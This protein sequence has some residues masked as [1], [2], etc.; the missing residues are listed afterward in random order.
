ML[1]VIKKMLIQL[2]STITL[3]DIKYSL[4][5]MVLGIS[6]SWIVLLIW[7]VACP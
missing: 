4:R 1:L 7:Y 5:G 2:T 3:Y 6:W